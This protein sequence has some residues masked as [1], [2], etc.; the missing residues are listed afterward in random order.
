M[1]E[2]QELWPRHLTTEL[3]EALKYARVVNIVG[4]RQVGKRTLVRDIFAEGRFITLDDEAMLLAIEE[5]P[6]GQLM[7]L[8]ASVQDGPVII[9][10]AQRSKKLALAIKRLVDEDPRKGQFVLTA[11][12]RGVKV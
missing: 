5:D 10:E 9:D 3:R 1:I 12:P 11:P 8:Q 4:P 2:E 6:L 7:A